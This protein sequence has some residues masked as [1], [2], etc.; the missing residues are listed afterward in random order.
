MPLNDE[1]PLLNLNSVICGTDFSEHSK[2]AGH[3][4]ALVAAQCD[5]R[6]LVAHAFTLAQA[7]IDVE[8]LRSQPSQQRKD[9][10][11]M[12]AAD[13]RALSTN[14]LRAE[15]CLVTGDPREQLPALAEKYSPSLLVLGT[16]GRGWLGRELLGSVAEE[17]LRSTRWPVL[18]VNAHARAANSAVPF[19]RILYATDFS[20]AAARAATFALAFARAF[21]SDLDV[22]HVIETETARHPEQ[23]A[24]RKERFSKALENL[25]R[26]DAGD[27]CN[28]ATF[29]EMGRAHQQTL[30]HI[31]ERSVDLLVLGLQK[32]EHLHL[33]VRLSRAFDLIVKADCPTLTITG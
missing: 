8:T 5:A 22:L 20:P 32:T 28:P 1:S 12:L 23:L 10:E 14:A 4:A 3:Y 15:P 27:F 25:V 9:L 21:G 17:I 19:R 26:E 7:A 33:H 29:V 6:L 30:H 13:A 31:Q 24:A 18:T 11:A 16:R 2:D